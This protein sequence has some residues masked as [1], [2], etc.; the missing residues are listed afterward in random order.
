MAARVSHKDM[1]GGP[2]AIR[3]EWR[4]YLSN[5]IL[6]TV[7]NLD[8]RDKLSDYESVL[9]RSLTWIAAFDGERLTGFANVAWDGGVHAFLLDLTVHPDYRHRGIG[10]RIVKEALAATAEH[11]GLEWM[12]VDSA[13]TLMDKLYL[14]AGFSPTDAGLVWMQ[15]VRDVGR[16]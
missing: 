8:P 5:E 14:P 15:D 2:M 7:L 12:H 6:G 1:L 4:P 3:Y 9:E 16:P 13:A 10:T 11:P